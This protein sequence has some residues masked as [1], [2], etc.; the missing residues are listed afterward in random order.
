[1]FYIKAA[2]N[3]GETIVFNIIIEYAQFL[4]QNI[5]TYLSPIFPEIMKISPWNNLEED[6]DP[7]GDE[8]CKK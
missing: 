1:M 4:E 8:K 3:L 7:T 5:R 6:D 2:P